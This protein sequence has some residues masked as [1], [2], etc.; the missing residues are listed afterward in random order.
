LLTQKQS[1]SR[2]AGAE[3]E[4]GRGNG[5]ALWENVEEEIAIQQSSSINSFPLPSPAQDSFKDLWLLDGVEAK[6]R[7]SSLLPPPPLRLMSLFSGSVSRLCTV[8]SSDGA[9]GLQLTLQTFALDEPLDQTN[10]NSN[11]TNRRE[12]TAPKK[13]LGNFPATELSS[14]SCS[15][16]AL[17]SLCFS[18][19]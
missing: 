18:V 12:H 14:A 2:G 16:S 15:R 1:L 3:A 9:N 4:M 5:T 13:I 11:S 7:R 10:S 19:F 6:T 17:L 8:L